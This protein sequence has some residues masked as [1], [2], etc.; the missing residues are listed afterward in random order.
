M[1]AESLSID[2]HPRALESHPIWGQ[3]QADR[4]IGPGPRRRKPLSLPLSPGRG[5]LI[6]RPAGEESAPPLVLCAEALPVQT[7]GPAI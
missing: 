4:G 5:L 2:S 7:G 6:I 3:A 1:A